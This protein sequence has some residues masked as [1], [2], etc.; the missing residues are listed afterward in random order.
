MRIGL[1][2]SALA[3]ATGAAGCFEPVH[4]FHEST[5]QRECRSDDL[6]AE[7]SHQ[8]ATGF[9]MGGVWV[10]NVSRS[11][12][13]IGGM[14][15]LVILEPDGRPVPVDVRRS[16][17]Y[18]T[19][20]TRP[21][22]V[23]KAHED[24]VVRTAWSDYCLHSLKAPLTYRLAFPSGVRMTARSDAAA[25]TCITQSR[26]AGILQITPLSRPIQPD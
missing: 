20:T 22:H 10:R 7:V 13:R 14:P 1:V 2:L 16:D 24:A 15:K 23:L 11:P 25:G 19:P 3:V 26:T 18:H 12:C 8:G 9:I 5:R 4:S 21:V 17:G 6:R